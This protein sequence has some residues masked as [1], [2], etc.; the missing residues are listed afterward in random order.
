M[1]TA[2]PQAMNNACAC[3]TVLAAL[4]TLGN[5]ALAAT[6]LTAFSAAG[7]VVVDGA[8]A[9]RLSTAAVESGE[10][11]LSAQGALLFD[12]LEPALQLA[13]GALPGDTYEG[14]GLVHRFD[15]AGPLQLSFDWSLATSGFDAGYRDRGFVALDGLLLAPLG[16]AAATPVN[17]RFSLTLGAG[18]HLLAFGLLDVNSTDGVST[19]A[20]S[21]FSVSA[22]PE[23]GTWAL[24]AGGLALCGVAARRRRGASPD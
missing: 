17:G 7:D 10:Q 11:P 12:A 5:P 13:P 8:G 20:I 16:E 19:L 14:S 1:T 22:V 6:D 4:A 9:A 21:N 2:A 3:F 23:P 18:S 15:S 24:L